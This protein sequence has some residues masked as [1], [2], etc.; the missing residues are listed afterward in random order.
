MS[1]LTA[2]RVGEGVDVEEVIKGYTKNFSYWQQTT[3]GLRHTQ[4]TVLEKFEYEQKQLPFMNP[5]DFFSFKKIKL[6]CKGM[7]E[8]LNPA[9]IFPLFVSSLC[10]TP[11]VVTHTRKHRSF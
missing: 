3:Q 9:I 1:Q 2:G 5:L 11:Y 4:K 8:N 10:P 6:R 7:S